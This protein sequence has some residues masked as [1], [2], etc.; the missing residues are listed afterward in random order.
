M[1]CRPAAEFDADLQWLRQAIA[2]AMAGQGVALGRRPL[3]DDLLRQR[4][5]VAP[6]ADDGV[7]RLI[8]LRPA[9]PRARPWRRW[10]SCWRR[11][12]A[13]KLIR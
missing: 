8:A 10:P 5:L 11:P 4:S 6:F 7:P 9:A 1:G 3:I 2:A 13:G 12:Q